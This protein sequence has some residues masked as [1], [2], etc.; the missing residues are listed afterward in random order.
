MSAHKLSIYIQI[1]M[2]SHYEWRPKH[3]SSIVPH[4]PHLLDS[5][6]DASPSF[7]DDPGM[8]GKGRID[9]TEHARLQIK[10]RRS[11]EARLVFRAQGSP[12]RASSSRRTSMCRRVSSMVCVRGVCIV[13]VGEHASND[14]NDV[15]AYPGYQGFAGL[16]RNKANKVRRTRERPQGWARSSFVRTQASAV[17]GVKSANGPHDWHESGPW[18][19]NGGGGEMTA[20]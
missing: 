9:N 14:C 11:V 7:N 10:Q 17:G 12:V 15:L 13:C 8:H 19:R 4:L 16:S 6:S 1:S 20:G 3:H 5:P 2:M 18:R